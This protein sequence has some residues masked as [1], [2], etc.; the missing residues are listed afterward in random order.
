MLKELYQEKA[1]N[2]GKKTGKE[3]V[4]IRTQLGPMT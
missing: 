3:A 4:S 1:E 2:R